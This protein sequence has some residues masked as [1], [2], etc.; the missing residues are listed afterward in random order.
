MK[1]ATENQHELLLLVNRVED[2]A[3]AVTERLSTDDFLMKREILRALVKRI[4]I[5]RDEIVVV[6][7]VN[8]GNDT[9]LEAGSDKTYGRS[10]PDCLRSNF[11]LS[12]HGVLD[13]MESMLKSITKP[14][15]KVHMI[16]YADDFI[17]TGSSKEQL[18]NTIKPAVTAFLFERGLTLSKEKTA[19]TSIT[20]G[21]DFLGFNVRNHKT[22][23]QVSITA[24]DCQV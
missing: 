21:F 8:P 11:S 23:T 5:Y 22:G 20:H 12:G 7:R 15:D 18:E 1:Q 14:A 3:A 4:E 17:I 10:L 19:I 9:S 6:F 13:G 2:F 24:K 16:R